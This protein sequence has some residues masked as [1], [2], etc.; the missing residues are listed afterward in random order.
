MAQFDTATVH[1]ISA[2][3]LV[4]LIEA[5]KADSEETEALLGQ[6]LA[7]YVGKLDALVLGCTHYPFV[8]QT[9]SRILGEKTLLFDGGAGTASQTQ[10]RLAQANLLNTEKGSVQIE[11]SL[12]TQEILQLSMKLLETG[13]A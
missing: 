9:L 4:E 12:G 2:P 5:G 1:R 8:K 3:G 13:D 6:I 7:P 11:N 10:R